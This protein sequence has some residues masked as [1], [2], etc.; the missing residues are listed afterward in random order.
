MLVPL[1]SITVPFTSGSLNNECIELFTRDNI[2]QLY[3]HLPL[4]YVGGVTVL[5]ESRQNCFILAR[6]LFLIQVQMAPLDL[7]QAVLSRVMEIK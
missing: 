1:A 5:F 7:Q 2:H 3:L 6:K 4:E